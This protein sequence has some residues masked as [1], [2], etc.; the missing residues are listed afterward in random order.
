[1]HG[2]GW[3]IPDHLTLAHLT[4]AQTHHQRVLRPDRRAFS[5]SKLE[6]ATGRK[7][8]AFAVIWD[9]LAATKQATTRMLPVSPSI[10]TTCRRRHIV[11]KD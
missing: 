9:H 10:R 1:L 3:F 4:L 6:Q 2:D 7:L 11:E 5:P 8:P